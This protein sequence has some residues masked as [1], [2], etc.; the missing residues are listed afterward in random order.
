MSVSGSP[1]GA[2]APRYDDPDLERTMLLGRCEFARGA[3]QRSEPG[4]KQRH[5]WAEILDEL[6]DRL[7]ELRARELVDRLREVR[8][9]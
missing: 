3:V 6:L 9:P 7:Y 8:A 1:Y 2:G 4:S 5:R